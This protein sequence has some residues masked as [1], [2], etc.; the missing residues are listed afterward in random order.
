MP[1]TRFNANQP[2]ADQLE[3]GEDICIITK[4]ALQLIIRENADARKDQADLSRR[5]AVSLERIADCMDGM[6]DVTTTSATVC[7]KLDDL[8]T[9]I[10]NS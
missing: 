9:T 5:I 10:K 7:Q 1:V 3:S 4:E 6:K 8:T 2:I